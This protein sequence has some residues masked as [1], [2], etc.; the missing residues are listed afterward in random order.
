MRIRAVAAALLLAV[1]PAAF[2]AA[3]TAAQPAKDDPVT[4]MA[5]QRFQEGVKL[6]DQG[7]FE[8]ARAA[9]LQAY[10]LKKHPAV[11]LN[12]AQSE[13]RSNH[14]VDAARHFSQYLRENPNA[15]AAESKAAQEGLSAARTRTARLDI[16][17]NI[18]GADIVVDDELLGRSPLPEPVD[19][20]GGARKVEVKMP[21]YKPVVVTTNARVGK[22]ETVNITLESESGAPVPAP[23]SPAGLEPT[24][25]RSASEKDEGVSISTEGRKPFFQWMLD[26][27]TA[28]VTGG[29]TVLGL[30]SGVAFTLLAN[31]ASNNADNIAQQILDHTAK[32]PELLNYGNENRTGNP[33]ADPI[34]VTSTTNYAPACKQLKDNLDIHDTDLTL[35]YVGWGLAG[36]GAVA[37]GVLYF[38]R[39]SPGKS[40]ASNVQPVV[41]APIVGSS[42]HGMVIGASF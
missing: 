22:T 3:P 9:F 25:D 42:V 6:Y 39:T 14:P 17:V 37:T 26:D 16:R 7:R 38:V 31:K 13:L 20:L 21:G 32:D 12:L 5:R 10:A 11:L 15:N 23:P 2:H 35:S 33:C 41:V 1:S 28:W 34:P 19:T 29:A 18:Q 24:S 8:E 4:E 40:T 36:A 27:H 30:T